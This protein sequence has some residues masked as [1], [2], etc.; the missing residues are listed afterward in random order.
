MTR[1]NKVSLSMVLH[2]VTPYVIDFCA[3]Q[4]LADQATG[5]AAASIVYGSL[6]PVMKLDSLWK[7][8]PLPNQTHFSLTVGKHPFATVYVMGSAVGVL[9]IH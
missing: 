5:S 2:T 9:I 6:A 4:Q 1:G 7:I 3:S 8:T